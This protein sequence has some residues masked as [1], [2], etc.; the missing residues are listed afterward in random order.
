MKTVEILFYSPNDPFE[1]CT[2]GN[3]VSPFF[4][5]SI[6]VHCAT[7]VHGESIA[8]VANAHISL[9]FVYPRRVEINTIFGVRGTRFL[10]TSTIP[11]FW[12]GKLSLRD[13]HECHNGKI[14]IMI[15]RSA[16]FCRT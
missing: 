6:I 3:Y 16:S 13:T 10:Y 9:S 11:S 1:C 5:P 8:V 12:L 2:T 15:C 4:F 14:I 7:A